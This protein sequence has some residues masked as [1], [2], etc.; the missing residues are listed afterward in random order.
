LDC[1]EN[2]DPKKDIESQF[3]VNVLAVAQTTR[4]ALP[5]MIKQ[6]QGHIINMCSMAGRS[7]A[8]D[9]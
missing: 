4:Q 9:F 1:L 6:R 8:L 3:D 5:V 2:L 7:P